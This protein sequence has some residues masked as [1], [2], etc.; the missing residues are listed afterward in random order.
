MLQFDSPAYFPLLIKSL[1]PTPLLLDK[2]K[3]VDAAAQVSDGGGS[4]PTC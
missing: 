2:K 4:T 1:L 3:I